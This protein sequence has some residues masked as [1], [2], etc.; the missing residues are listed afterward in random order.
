MLRLLVG[1]FVCV[2][3]LLPQTVLAKSKIDM[4]RDYAKIEKISEARQLLD[5]VILADPLNADVH[6]RAGLV[7]QQLG[8]IRNFILAA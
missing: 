2:A 3:L 1:L 5:E 4:A 7:Y 6:Y 8:D